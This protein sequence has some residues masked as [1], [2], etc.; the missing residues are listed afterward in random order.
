MK[1]ISIE[2]KTSIIN[3]FNNGESVSELTEATGVARRLS[4]Y[5]F[6]I[7]IQFGPPEVHSGFR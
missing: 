1:Q 3:R 5:L 2:T 4:T 7:M 6:F